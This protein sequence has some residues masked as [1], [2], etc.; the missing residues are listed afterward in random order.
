MVAVALAAAGAEARP[1][2]QRRAAVETPRG[3]VRG[4]GDGA[5]HVGKLR[6]RP[7][8]FRPLMSR[9]HDPDWEALCRGDAG[10]LRRVYEAHAVSLLRYGRRF[11]QLPAVEDALHDLF[12]RLW[13]R[14]DRL[15]PTAKPLPYLLV[16]LRNALLRDSKRAARHAG[17][18][19]APADE[20]A[21]SVEDLIVGAETD[22]AR[23]TALQRAIARLSPREREIVQLRFGEGVDYEDIT[24]VMG[25]SYGSAR[26]TLTRALGKLRDCLAIVALAMVTNAA[27]ASLLLERLTQRPS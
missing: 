10:A 16:S 24:E 9:V 13:E 4:V 22:A 17:L 2:R 6:P 11:A 12:V 25:I 20:G 14:H 5:R 19:D 8:Y 3:I 23:V 27:L 7:R 26:N 15:D 21:A 18:D 1:G